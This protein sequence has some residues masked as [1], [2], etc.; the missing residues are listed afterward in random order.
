METWN[1]VGW[2]YGMTVVLVLAIAIFMYMRVRRSQ[3]RRG[4]EPGKISV[5]KPP[6][7]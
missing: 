4:E 5:P 7:S 3:R 2:Q 1:F 6:Q